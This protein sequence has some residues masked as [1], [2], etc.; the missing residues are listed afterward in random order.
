MKF[1]PKTLLT[2]SG[3]LIFVLLQLIGPPQNMQREAFMVL[4]S[5]IWIAIWW[6]TEVIPIPATSL[7]PI[8][9]FPLT[10]ALDIQS[11]AQ[12][13]ASP[14][15]FLFVGG[16]ILAIAI[17]KWNLHKR[18]ALI[19]VS[20]VGVSPPRII[21]GFML[22][23]AGLSMWISNTATT[24]MMLPLAVA[25]ISQFLTENKDRFAKALML[26]I[27]YAASIGGIAT[28]I[29]TPTNLILSGVLEKLYGIEISFASW[30]LFALP[31]SIILF[32]I[33]WQY[34]VHVAFPLKNWKFS[35]GIEEINK[36]LKLLGKVSYEEKWLL[37][38]FFTTAFAWIFRS[39]LLSG[40][41]PGLDDSIIALL[42][43]TILFVIP[44]K[45][46]ESKLMDWE[47]AVKLPWGIVLLFGGGL[48]LAVG[49]QE[50]GLSDWIGNQLYGAGVLP[51]I[52]LM[53]IVITLV[54]FLT[55]IT[56]NIATASMILPILGSI[57]LAINVHPFALMIGATLAASCA[58]MLPVATPPNAVVFGSGY[59]KMKD[60]IRAGFALNI[61]SIILILFFTYLLLSPLWGI[62]MNA[63][64]EEFK[65]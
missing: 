29:G 30:F 48:S 62:D 47:S 14:I 26:S 60:M 18:I 57:A 35:A 25:V 17:E 58:F 53:F 33:C 15:I 39:F 42:A 22:A 36:E 23:S 54:N 45:D 38:V 3:P 32:I 5:T 9:L 46:G 11:T 64:P 1:W 61:I 37:A 40:I 65:Q 24:V 28:L 50:S 59:L 34:L 4:A 27:A 51:L 8:I 63:F 7:L 55:E 20:K 19:I 6:I 43:G 41:L 44:A 16:F 31:I 56:S 13:Y 52:L 21:L 10:G 49:F 2:L 12:A